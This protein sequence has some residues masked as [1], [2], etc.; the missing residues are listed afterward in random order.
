MQL[1][2]PPEVEALVQKQLSSGRYRS[3]VDVVLAAMQ[4]LQQQ[5]AEDIYKGRLAE[6]REDTRIGWEAYQRGDHVDGP[7]TIEQIRANLHEAHRTQES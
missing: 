5:Q 4:S 1:I 2:L 3:P 6:L 7:S